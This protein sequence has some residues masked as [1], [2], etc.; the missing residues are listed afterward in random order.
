MRRWNQGLVSNQDCLCPRGLPAG[1]MLLLT[2]C[3]CVFVSWFLCLSVHACSPLH[4]SSSFIHSADLY[5]VAAMC[6]LWVVV[7]RPWSPCSPCCGGGNKTQLSRW[8]IKCLWWYLQRGNKTGWVGVGCFGLGHRGGGV[9][10]E[11]WMRGEPA[12]HKSGRGRLG[13]RL[14]QPWGSA[15]GT[16][17]GER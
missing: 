11:I 10:A 6:H 1:H 2:V 5:R 4:P 3:V 16:G 8:V 15:M 7:T 9:W 13:R 12:W 14:G 17:W